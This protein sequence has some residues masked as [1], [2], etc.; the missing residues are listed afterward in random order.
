MHKV[1][2]RRLPTLGPAQL[3]KPVAAELG[4]RGG[5]ARMAKLSVEERQAIGRRG[6]AIRGARRAE[7]S[8]R[9]TALACAGS[10]AL[11]MNLARAR[12]SVAR[13]GDYAMMSRLA[14]WQM[15]VIGMAAAAALFGAGMV[16]AKF[17]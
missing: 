15:A 6:A 11:G 8:P 2:S 1:H 16:F 7:T 17:F 3:L 5:V 13:L 10:P 12:C 9:R 4:R 14:P